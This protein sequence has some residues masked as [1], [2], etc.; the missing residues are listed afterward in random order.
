MSGTSQVDEHWQAVWAGALDAVEVDVE[1]AER[2]L[3]QWHRGDA[4][5][6]PAAAQDWVAPALLGPMPRQFEDRA[7]LL[8][9]R[10]SE[11]AARL[12]SAMV[13]ARSQQRGL[14]KLN[15]AEHAP[16]FVDTAF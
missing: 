15:Q 4:P 3:E 2:L 7:R 8:L 1:R 5:A 12:A 10:Q 6:A 14:S 13:Q 11:V 9:A 16:V